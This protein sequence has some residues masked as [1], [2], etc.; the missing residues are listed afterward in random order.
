MSFLV[1]HWGSWRCTRWAGH[2]FPMRSM[3]SAWFLS[4]QS[5]CLLVDGTKHS[6]AV[7][8]MV[9]RRVIH[10]AFTSCSSKRMVSSC[11]SKAS[12][13][14]YLDRMSF[15]FVMFSHFDVYL[16]CGLVL[17]WTLMLSL[18]IIRW[19]SVQHSAPHTVL[20]TLISCLSLHL[21]MT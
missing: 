13:N 12:T 7:L 16:P 14:H 6:I 1:V 10:A 3:I 21:T 2:F 5:L 11:S 8:Y 4:N 20:I 9:S 17:G 18:E 15:S 19:W